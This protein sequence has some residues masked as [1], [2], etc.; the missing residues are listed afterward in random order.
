MPRLFA[1]AF[2]FEACIIMHYRF[3]TAAKLLLIIIKT[4][5]WSNQILNQTMTLRTARFIC[6]LS[7]IADGPLMARHIAL[8][9]T[10][11]MAA[12]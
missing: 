1:F 10:L 11:A 3:I 2:Y 5:Y 12:K 9:M 8:A 7:D 6:P 4:I